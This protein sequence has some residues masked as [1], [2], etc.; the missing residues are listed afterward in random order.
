MSYN[1]NYKKNTSWTINVPF[2]TIKKHKVDFFLWF[3]FVILAGQLGTII[4][5]IC[6]VTY[7]DWSLLESLYVDSLYGNYFT[8]ALVLMA[9]IL[10]P[11][12]IRLINKNKGKTEFRTIVILFTS[13]L[14][15]LIFFTGI[16]L[17]VS[18]QQKVQKPDHISFKPSDI[19]QIV[20]FIISIIMAIYYFG[21]EKMSDHDELKV[22]DDDYLKK[23]NKNVDKL[24]KQVIK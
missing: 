7:G 8:F 9:S 4:N 13:F 18:T 20:L 19:I 6:R 1:K 2:K 17:S 16:C 12:F 21:I 24:G 22:Y 15:I 3:L 5:V 11:I 23:E 14:I 10:G